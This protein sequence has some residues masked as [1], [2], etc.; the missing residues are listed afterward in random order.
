MTLLGISL[1]LIAIAGYA[2]YRHFKTR[3]NSV[4][5]SGR[6]NKKR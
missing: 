5:R 3:Q 6:G 1:V 2:I 4:L